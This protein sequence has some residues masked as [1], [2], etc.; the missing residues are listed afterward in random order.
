M[1]RAIL[2]IILNTS[3]FMVV[4]SQTIFDIDLLETKMEGEAVVRSYNNFISRC[5]AYW[6]LGSDGAVVAFDNA[7]IRDAEG[8]LLFRDSFTS[9]KLEWNYFGGAWELS[10]GRLCQQDIRTTSTDMQVCYVSPGHDGSIAVEAIRQSG[11]GGFILVFSLTDRENFV[12]WSL[13]IDGNTSKVEQSTD[14]SLQTL[15]SAD[16]FL[17]SNRNYRMEAIFSGE[18]V[19]LSLDGE[20]IH[21]VTLDD[22]PKLSATATCSPDF[23][24]L[25]IHVVNNTDIPQPTT[26]RIHHA[27][28][29]NATIQINDVERPVSLSD[30]SGIY[31]ILDASSTTYYILQLS[32]EVQSAIDVPISDNILPDRKKNEWEGVYD[33]SGRKI[34]TKHHGLAPGIYMINSKKHFIR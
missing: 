30:A 22:T 8:Q 15:C 18:N 2:Y 16:I 6:G 27:D 1:K 10:S 17:Q 4:H 34:D 3:F 12:R 31:T 26:L 9:E 20:I 25:R 33:L 23:S 5:D 14:G 11:S 13:G 24:A 28:I 32:G 7:E 29:E 19:A 21:K